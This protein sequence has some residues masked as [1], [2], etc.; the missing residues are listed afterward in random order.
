MSQYIFVYG[1]LKRGHGNHH[2]LKDCDL[3]G[4]GRVKGCVLLDMGGYP[5]MIPARGKDEKAGQAIGEVYFV[6][7]GHRREV[8]A[9]LDMLEKAYQEYL[10]I[11]IEVECGGHIRKCLAYL[12]MVT[13]VG[14][15]TGGDWG[16][17][18]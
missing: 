13:V 2:L 11:T 18:S 16:V 3:V 9:R 4:P 15:I 5:G 12:Y 14:G 8:R 6:P 10:P 17:P 1:T 7:R